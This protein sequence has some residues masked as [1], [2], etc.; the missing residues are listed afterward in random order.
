M[1]YSPLNYALNLIKIRDRSEGEVRQKMKLKGF[2]ADETEA[3]IA[4]LKET[5]LLDDERFVSSYI[6][7]QQNMGRGTTRIKFRLQCLKIDDALI[8]AGLAEVSEEDESERAGELVERWIKKNG[9][10]ENAKEKLIR[11]MMARG[12]DYGTIK[13]VLEKT[14]F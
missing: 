10:K 3:V 7:S 9:S 11:F 2:F 14:K 6:R 5:K 1:K 12:F 8:K 13:S 4:K